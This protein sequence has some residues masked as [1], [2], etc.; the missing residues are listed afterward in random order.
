MRDWIAN[1]GEPSLAGWRAHRDAVRTFARLHDLDSFALLHPDSAE[2]LGYAGSDRARRSIEL[3][4]KQAQAH[5]RRDR[6]DAPPVD[7]QK[8]A[9]VT[10]GGQPTGRR[11]R[12]AGA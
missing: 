7:I 10:A 8:A 2:N 6:V 4:R 9:A 3:A 11:L 1:G 12:G 5:Q